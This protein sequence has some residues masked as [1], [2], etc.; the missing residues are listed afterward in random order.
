MKQDRQNFLFPIKQEVSRQTGSSRASHLVEVVDDVSRVPVLELW[1]GDVD[2]LHLLPLQHPDPLL[3]LPQLEL[4]WQL[5]LH[6]LKPVKPA[7]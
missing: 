4:V 6:L 2:E 3:Q 7:S 5:Q 1:H